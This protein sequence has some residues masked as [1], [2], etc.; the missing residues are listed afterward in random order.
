MILAHCSLCL[1]SSND[2]SASASRTSSTF[3]DSTCTQLGDVSQT[4]LQPGVAMSLRS[5]QRSMGRS[6]GL[7]DRPP[8]VVV[9]VSGGDP[10][11]N[12]VTGSA[13][14]G[15]PHMG[16]HH[17]D[18]AGLEL[19]TSG[20]PP[21]LASKV[22]GLQALECCGAILAHCNLHILDSKM[23]FRH[24]GQAGLEPLT[25]DDLPTSASQSVGLLSLVFVAQAGV[26]RCDLGS[27]Q[28]P[29]PGFKTFSCL[30]LLSSWDYRWGFSMLVR[31][32]SNS[33]PQVI[34][35]PWPPKVLGLQTESLI[36]LPRLEHSGTISAY[37]NV[38][39]L[40]S[41][42]GFHHVG[43][44]GLELLTSSNPPTLASQS[45]GII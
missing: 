14:C 25:S 4:P 2:S 42:T 28:P 19:P 8:Q 16:F 43:Q 6:N 17:V 18:Q 30:S 24:V 44:A 26:Q 22:L 31:L 1:P 39:L 11:V 33:R 5:S 15:G 3:S 35:L 45:A 21:A 27:S 29:P 10:D 7:L 37:C 41:K 12:K 36:L 20:D 23:G 9:S 40:G 32:V 13:L 34:C 38:C